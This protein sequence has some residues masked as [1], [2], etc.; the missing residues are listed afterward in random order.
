MTFAIITHVPHTAAGAHYFAYAPYVREMNI[1]AKHVTELI[2]VA[3]LVKSERTA[4][5]TAYHSPKIKF[6]PVDSFDVL[7]ASGL[8]KTLLKIP[9]ISWQ[10]YKAMR[11]AD[12]IHLRCPGNIGLLGCVIQIAFPSKSKTA[13]YAGNWDPKSKQPWTYKLQQWIL[14][15]T[16]LTR[17]MQVL[18][19]GEWEGSTKNIKPFFTATYTEADKVPIITRN[20][21]DPIHFVF[22]GALVAGKN[23]LY[24][25]QLIERLVEKGHHVRLTLFGEGKER[26]QLEYYCSVNKLENCVVLKGNQTK[27]TIQKA[28]QDSHFVILPSQSEGWPKV[29]AE[30]MFWGCVPIATKVSCVP[31]MLDFGNRGLVLNMNLEKDSAVIES[32]LNDQALFDSKQMKGAAWSRG[33]TMDVFESEIK[34]LLLD[35]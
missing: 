31:F 1:W 17:N 10:I 16:F 20:L 14:S 15:N 30:G 6:L 13:K 19:Y 26:Q 12:H 4:V 34:K 33:Y 29:I 23:P 11:S 24:A 9:T 21:K 7:S 25:I 2:V 35:S 32:V 3:P 27:D 18:V 28:Y 5:D 8:L 22:V